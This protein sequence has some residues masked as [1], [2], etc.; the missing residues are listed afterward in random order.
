LYGEIRAFLSTRGTPIGL[1]DL[2]QPQFTSLATSNAHAALIHEPKLASQRFR[3]EAHERSLA[4]SLNRRI[5]A[6]VCTAGRRTTI[7]KSF[8]ADTRP[9]GNSLVELPGR[10]PISIALDRVENPVIVLCPV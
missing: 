10:R 2:M 5:A 6:I 7:P 1:I 8:S 4:C 3:V 9:A